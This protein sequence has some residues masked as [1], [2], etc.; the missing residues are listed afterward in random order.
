MPAV[1][2][3]WSVKDI[4]SWPLVVGQVV[5]W[6]RPD[7][8]WVPP[9]G[10]RPEDSLPVFVSLPAGQDPEGSGWRESERY[11]AVLLIGPDGSTVAVAAADW[12]HGE[13]CTLRLAG[14]LACWNER[15]KWFGLSMTKKAHEALTA[16]VRAL[17]AQANQEMSQ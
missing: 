4:S 9:P 7:P 10:L 17:I 15:K 16:R 1:K 12:F 8:A 6:R 3:N 11:R 14:V 2:R 5:R 13:Y